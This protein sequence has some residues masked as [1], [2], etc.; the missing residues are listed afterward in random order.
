MK[1]IV[2]VAL[3]AVWV[4]TGCF[5]PS[6]GGETDTAATETAPATDSDV[7]TSAG[8]GSSGGSMT[9][10]PPGTTTTSPTA[11][12]TVGGDTTEGTDTMAG[13]STGTTG[14]QAG[15]AGFGGAVAYINFDGADLEIGVVDNAPNGITNNDVL[16]GSWPAYGDPDAEAVFDTMLAHW[17]SFD[18]CLTMEPPQVADYDMIVVQSVAYMGN[19]NVVSLG[20]A[21]CS[22]T[23]INNVDVLFLSTNNNL[24]TITKAIAVSKA[25]AQRFGLDSVMADEDIMNQFIANTL[26]GASFTNM[27]LPLGTASTCGGGGPCPAGTQNAFAMLTDIFGP[28]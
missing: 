6:G 12:T 1:R 18:I 21:D 15:C 25:L 24:P 8:P 9:S 13:D 2:G 20:A 22:N 7:S 4:T 3:G 17:A 5:N 27:C 10:G 19:D 16:V 26:N 11:T 28:A 14:G 23:T